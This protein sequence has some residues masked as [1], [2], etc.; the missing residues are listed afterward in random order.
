MICFCECKVYPFV[1]GVAKY[2]PS[3]RDIDLIRRT[4][5]D[6]FDF[7]YDLGTDIYTHIFEAAPEARPLFP[8]L[9]EAGS[10]WQRMPA[11]RTQ[12]LKF[13]QVISQTIK[14]LGRSDTHL[15]EYLCNVGAMHV[16]LAVERGFSSD[17]WRTFRDAIDST[18]R[19]RIDQGVFDARLNVN[20]RPDALRAWTN[21]SVLIIQTMHEGYANKI[22]QMM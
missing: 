10:N 15:Y 22:K 4:W 6:D 18:M 7:L 11:F 14:N 16:R 2:H 20:D 17:L 21:M 19:K 1:V 8:T 3:D 12:A 5:L 9:V 13:V